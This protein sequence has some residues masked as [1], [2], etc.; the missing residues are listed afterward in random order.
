MA[1]HFIN[2]EITTTKVTAAKME[3][4]NGSVNAENLEDVI[5][6]GNVSLEKANKEIKKIYGEG[7]TAFSVEANTHKYSI[8]TELFVKHAT[9]VTD[10]QE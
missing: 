3:L 9:I 10:E 6:I 4:V 5:L 2:R 7:A 1:R 8:P